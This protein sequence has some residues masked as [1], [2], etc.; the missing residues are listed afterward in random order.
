MFVC[1][2][3]NCTVVCG[4]SIC[5]RPQQQL[6]VTFGK[7]LQKFLSLACCR[8][9]CG[10]IPSFWEDF[11][12][13]RKH[14][15]LHDTKTWSGSTLS[16][17]PSWEQNTGCP[18]HCWDVIPKMMFTNQDL[19]IQKIYET[20]LQCLFVIS[21][22]SQNVDHSL[23]VGVRPL[24]RSPIAWCS[25]R[26][27]IGGKVILFHKLQSSQA[28]TLPPWIPKVIPSKLTKEKFPGREN[29]L[30]SEVNV[31]LNQER[32]ASNSSRRK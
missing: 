8:F 22:N 5:A 25:M 2:G 28:K 24:W 32:H 1:S 10:L 21:K 4:S 19:Y 13:P 12:L 20:F 11:L 23:L 18:T 31:I 16:I 7:H 27:K 30:H 17:F 15:V 26:E 6:T 9:L 14:V 3:F 29:V